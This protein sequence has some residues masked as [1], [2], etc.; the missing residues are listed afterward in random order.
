[1]EGKMV[2]IKLKG[3][4]ETA[5][6]PMQRTLYRRPEESESTLFMSDGSPAGRLWIDELDGLVE[7]NRY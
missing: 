5:K 7:T 4:A 6:K 2:L 3:D 1:M